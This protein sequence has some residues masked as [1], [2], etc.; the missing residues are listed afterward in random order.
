MRSNAG[1]KTL[2]CPT[3]AD[4]SLSD[5]YEECVSSVF[6]AQTGCRKKEAGKEGKKTDDKV[7]IAFLTERF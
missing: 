2:T 3:P 1:T 6:K 4:W 5:S 7:C